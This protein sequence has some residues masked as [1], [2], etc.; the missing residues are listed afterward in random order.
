MK[1]GITLPPPEKLDQHQEK[2]LI[3][4][5]ILKLAQVI[6]E[7][8]V[9]EWN[10]KLYLQTKGCPTGLRPSGPLSRLVMG[11]WRKGTIDKAELCT[12]L[13]TINPIKFSRLDFHALEKY[14]DDVFS[15][16]NKLP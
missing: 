13:A 1:G 7:T 6:F 2:A 5:V 15:A 10:G 9:Y 16:S 8:H 14:V 12:A 11:K 3:A 4:A